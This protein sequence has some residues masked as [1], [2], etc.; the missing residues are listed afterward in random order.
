MN[1]LVS[2][3]QW[4]IARVGDALDWLSDYGIT[5]NGVMTAAIV[6]YMLPIVPALMA[7]HWFAVAVL[8]FVSL[9]WAVDKNP[10]PKENHSPLGAG[11]RVTIVIIAVGF[12]GWF[13]HDSL[14]GTLDLG[15]A[16]STQST[17]AV[18]VLYYLAASKP[19]GKRK[20]RESVSTAEI[21]ALAAACR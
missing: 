13:I 18:A 19:R 4:L 15:F 16:L 2:V 12:V 8:A 3:D 10:M 6:V 20:P 7:R 21:K 11:F 17:I 1:W 14:L 9:T 5:R